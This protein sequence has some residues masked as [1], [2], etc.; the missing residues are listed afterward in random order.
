MRNTIIISVYEQTIEISLTERKE[1]TTKTSK[2]FELNEPL[3]NVV[4]WVEKLNTK[5]RRRRMKTYK[6]TFKTKQDIGVVL[7]ELEAWCV[8]RS[9][10][11]VSG[12]DFFLYHVN[13][14]VLDVVSETLPSNRYVVEEE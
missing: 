13:E 5:E 8:F 10:Y 9:S 6:V 11:E 3:E 2:E 1:T 14:N 4:N 7:Y 12:T